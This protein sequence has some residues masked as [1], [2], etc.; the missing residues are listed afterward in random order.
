MSEISLADFKNVD[1]RVARIVDVQEVTGADRLWRLTV[2]IGA[3]KKEMVAGIKAHYPKESL[4]G[5]LVVV[6]NNLTPAVIRGVES[7]GMLLAAKDAAGLVLLSVDK[8]LAPG[9]IIG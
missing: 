9:S 2:D 7:R 3:E 8:E 6:V 5:R 4:V 1:L